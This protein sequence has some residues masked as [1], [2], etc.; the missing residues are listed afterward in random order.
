MLR[1][2]AVLTAL[3]QARMAPKKAMVPHAP[4]CRQ[5][6]SIV[7]Q[8]GTKKPGLAATTC[9]SEPVLNRTAELEGGNQ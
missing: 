5:L 7:A 1:D 8:F 2:L 6:G 9:E 4:A 3:L